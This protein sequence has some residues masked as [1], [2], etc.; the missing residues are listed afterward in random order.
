MKVIK[1]VSSALLVS[2]LFATAT[3]A[4]PTQLVNNGGFETGTLAGW[5]TT[6][7]GNGICPT[8]NQDWNV[9]NTGTATGCNP[10][11]DPLGSIFAAY[12]QNDGAGPLT[13]KL[14]QSFGVAPGTTGGAFSFD[15]SSSNE[16]DPE[17]T[18]KVS[19]T[20]EMSLASI[21]LYNASTSSSDA[22]W[23]ALSGDISAFLAGAAGNSVL[24]SFDN[25]I[26]STWS[27]PAGLGIDNVSILAEV[28]TVPE[29]ASLALFGFG[30]SCLVASRR[31]QAKI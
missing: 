6:G 27:G 2:S 11:A 29:P 4:A 26:P 30:L 18:L 20:D 13:Y 10:V 31:K 17:R 16:S 19:L 25:F 9:S 7:L 12:V 5:S 28:S 23:Q 8:T 22:S 14:A 21:I 24:L 15:L 1:L 3:I